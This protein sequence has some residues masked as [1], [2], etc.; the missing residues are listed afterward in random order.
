MNKTIL[1]CLAV[2]SLA[3]LRHPATAQSPHGMTES[4][5]TP[6]R[7]FNTGEKK[8]SDFEAMLADL[9]R[10]D[11]I[12]VGEQHDDPATH[13]LERAILEGLLRRRGASVVVV[14]EM[15]ERDVQPVLDD[16]L[17]GKISE[18]EF[19]KNSRPW[20]HYAT[21]YRPLVEFARAHGWRVVAGNVP[22]RYASQVA[23]G[24]LG[25]V[26]KLPAAE[27]AFV[28]KQFN[29]PMDDYYKRFAETM[30]SHPG[31]SAHGA[32]V[33]NGKAD[34]QAE[35]KENRA[36]IEK[37]YLAQCVKDETMGESVASIHLNSSTPGPLIVHF[38]GAFHSDY[39]QGTAAR[40]QQRLPKAGVKV[41][42][43]IP[44]ENLDS[45]KADDDLKRADY[46][47]YTLKP[48]TVKSEK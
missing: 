13:R 21:D 22:R 47:I 35:E 20:P 19:L 31:A 45:I 5:Y 12:F 9:A 40:A 10:A 28:A 18:E 15:F 37:F 3:V 26:E 34:S 17:A 39:H 8:F 14:L 6:Q 7:V 42:S 1:F 48:K 41:I 38:N 32:A 16:Y 27:R 33:G 44:A 11:V 30:S 36:I 23:K 25:E 43:I 24:G 2:V 46:L 4:G 29:C